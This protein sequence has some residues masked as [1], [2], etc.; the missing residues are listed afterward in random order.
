MHF[1]RYIHVYVIKFTD[2][3]AW[4]GRRL[5]WR[6]IEKTMP[7]TQIPYVGDYAQIICALCNKFRPPLSSGTY[8]KDFG[9]VFSENI[10]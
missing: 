10:K 8:E 5:T 4:M 3:V 6:L 7:N 2:Q 1:L 9:A